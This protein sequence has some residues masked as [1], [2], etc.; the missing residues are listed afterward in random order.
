MKLS[1]QTYGTHIGHKLHVEENGNLVQLICDTCGCVAA[2]WERPVE[3]VIYVASRCTDP[4]SSKMKENTELTAVFA[5]KI[6]KATYTHTV[7]PHADM[8]GVLDDRDKDQ[9]DAIIEFDNAILDRCDR[10][11]VNR[12]DIGVSFGATEECIR[13]SKYG[14]KITGFTYN[15]LEDTITVTSVTTGG[16][17]LCTEHSFLLW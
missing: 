8:F 1:V 9:R 10:V 13:A 3:E 5:D 12:E 6:A 2:S 16:G 4:V 14:K 11:F 17:F 7:A 15:S